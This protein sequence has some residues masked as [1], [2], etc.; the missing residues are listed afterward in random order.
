MSV[1]Q[2][3]LLV[4]PNGTQIEP[5]RQAR[6]IYFDEVTCARYVCEPNVW[7]FKLLQGH[8]LRTWKK[9]T[10]I[11]LPATASVKAN[12]KIWWK[13][14]PRLKGKYLKNAPKAES[15]APTGSSAVSTPTT[16]IVACKTH[17]PFN[18]VKLWRKA[19]RSTRRR[20]RL[21]GSLVQNQSSHRCQVRHWFQAVGRNEDEVKL[22]WQ[23][24]LQLH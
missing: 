4:L 24:S 22:S 11:W 16:I 2:F 17:P 21:M 18:I 1:L 5:I 20:W 6:F 9:S 12:G 7:D 23:I 15:T 3:Q 10:E 13:T 19:Q 14:I 8:F